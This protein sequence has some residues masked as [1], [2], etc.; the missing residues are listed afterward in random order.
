LSTEIYKGNT[1]PLSL[2]LTKPKPRVISINH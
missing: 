1:N 2:S